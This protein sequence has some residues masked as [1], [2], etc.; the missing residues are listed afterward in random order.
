[1]PKFLRKACPS[2]LPAL[3]SSLATHNQVLTTTSFSTW[4]SSIL[5]PAWTITRDIRDQKSNSMA[6]ISPATITRDIRDQ[7]IKFDG[8][9]F[10]WASAVSKQCGDDRP[11]SSAA[12]ENESDALMKHRSM[13]PMEVWAISGMMRDAQEEYD[14]KPEPAQPSL[15]RLASRARSRFRSLFNSASSRKHS[16]SFC[17]AATPSRVVS[18]APFGT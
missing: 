6:K 5:S 17:Q 11:Q 14:G 13:L 8:E 2:R 10:R 16:C 9:N 7:K 12:G 4:R 1:M 18:S 15:H 3:A